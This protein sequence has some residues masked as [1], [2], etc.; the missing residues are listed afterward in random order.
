MSKS[1]IPG[2]S[3][4]LSE[5]EVPSLMGIARL[6]ILYATYVTPL[7]NLRKIKSFLYSLRRN[8][9]YIYFG[10]S[11]TLNETVSEMVQGGA[12]QRN[13]WL[14]IKLPPTYKPTKVAMHLLKKYEKFLKVRLKIIGLLCSDCNHFNFIK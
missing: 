13:R 6:M 4:E 2:K 3:M 14:G 9:M 11:K 8:G 7:A 5:G 12:L 1:R 10:N